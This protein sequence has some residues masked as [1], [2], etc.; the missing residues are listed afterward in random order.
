MMGLIF[1]LLIAEAADHALG[2]YNSVADGIIMIATL[3]LELPHQGAQLRFRRHAPRVPH[4][5]G[6]YEPSSTGGH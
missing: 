1:D 5:R 4:P 3:M 2:K 6:A